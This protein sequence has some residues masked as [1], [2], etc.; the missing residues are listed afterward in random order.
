VMAVAT[1]TVNKFEPKSRAPLDVVVVM[2]R[3]GEL[4]CLI[5]E[6]LFLSKFLISTFNKGSMGGEKI[7]LAKEALE[8]MVDQ[9]KATDKCECFFALFDFAL[10]VQLK[11]SL[12]RQSG[13]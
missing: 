7:K 8:F 2:D 1:L 10:H 3:S 11:F 5:A 13:W 4:W 12:R 9:F 6:F